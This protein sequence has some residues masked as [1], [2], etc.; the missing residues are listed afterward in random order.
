MNNTLF[1]EKI[2]A[3]QKD[4]HG[5]IDEACK[6]AKIAMHKRI[7]T[8][9]EKIYFESALFLGYWLL[10]WFFLGTL[11]G[12]FVCKDEMLRIVRVGESFIFLF[13]FYAINFERLRVTPERCKISTQSIC[14]I[15]LIAFV[16]YFGF[17][18]IL[19]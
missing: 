5:R 13:L 4:F 9:F 7:N 17:S 16:S 19:R 1:D 11:I 3:L 2:V 8:A 14:A 6:E 10:A 12:I 15:N 18:F